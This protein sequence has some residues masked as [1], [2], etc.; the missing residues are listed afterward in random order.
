MQDLNEY[1]TYNSSEESVDQTCAKQDD[2]TVRPPVAEEP[3]VNKN[4]ALIITGLLGWSGLNDFIWGNWICGWIK[5]VINVISFNI[6]NGDHD[7]LVAFFPV[8]LCIWVIVDIARIS[9][10]SFFK[11][12]N[13]SEG[14]KSLE[15]VLGLSFIVILIGCIA[16][17]I[18]EY[19]DS[20]KI[21]NGKVA[22]VREII[23]T[24]NQNEAYAEKSFDGPCFTIAGQVK[25]VEKGLLE[26]FVV[27]FEGVGID[28]FNLDN[29][30]IDMELNFSTKQEDEL[31]KVR[32]GDFVAASCIGRG[33]ALSLYI[34]DKCQLKVVKKGKR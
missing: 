10:N 18:R 34:A 7:V 15:A 21:D 4:N 14:S 2:N 9:D 13:V 8:I 19:S 16:F 26:G 32:R 12:S 31:L 3:S 23:N 33:V 25:S 27:K 30:I 6:D 29:K 24:Y 20:R 5:I 17:F 28:V 1:K 22:S 11:K